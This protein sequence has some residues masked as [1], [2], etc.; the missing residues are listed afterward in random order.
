CG[1]GAWSPQQA[2]R[3]KPEPVGKHRQNAHPA[4]HAE[5]RSPQSNRGG[6]PLAD[7]YRGIAAASTYLLR[8]ARD[9]ILAECVVK[10]VQ[11]RPLGVERNRAVACLDEYLGRH[12]GN[13]VQSLL[14]DPRILHSNFRRVV[15]L[16]GALVDKS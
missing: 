6:S 11:Q 10:A 5:I 16:V 15:R 12:S 4:Y 8:L 7:A 9:S 1:T 3:R 14:R 2:D 13:Y